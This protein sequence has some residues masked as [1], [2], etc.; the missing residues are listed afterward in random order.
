MEKA[1]YEA[2]PKSTFFVYPLFRKMFFNKQKI[3]RNIFY[4]T[5]LINIV[6]VRSSWQHNPND[7]EF[8]M[9]D[10]RY[11]TNTTLKNLFSI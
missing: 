11:Q 8:D 9:P 3:F 5:A 6:E 1:K 4:L 10:I 2:C 7:C